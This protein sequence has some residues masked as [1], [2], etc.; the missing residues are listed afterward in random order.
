MMVS[1]QIIVRAAMRVSGALRRLARPSKP[2]NRKLSSRAKS[3]RVSVSMLTPG[4]Y[5]GGFFPL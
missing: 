4:V 2:G 3:A 5:V 1:H